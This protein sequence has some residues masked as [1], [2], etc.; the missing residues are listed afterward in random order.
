MG[1]FGYTED[2]PEYSDFFY[3]ATINILK[4]LRRLEFQL[5][6][7]PIMAR[8]IRIRAEKYYVVH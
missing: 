3:M 7:S 5:L 1:S 8:I 2:D 6:G 4:I